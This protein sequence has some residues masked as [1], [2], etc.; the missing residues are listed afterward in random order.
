MVSLDLKHT[1]ASFSPGSIDSLY[2]RV[3]QVPSSRD[4]AIFGSTDDR[5][6]TTDKQIA[7]PLLRMR[8]RGNN[9]QNVKIMI[10]FQAFLFLVH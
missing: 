5:R 6:Q 3:A 9:S 7:L 10:I 4:M 2:L 1:E 8:T